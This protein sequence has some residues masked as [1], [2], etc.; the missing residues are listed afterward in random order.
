MKGLMRTTTTLEP[1]VATLVERRMKA[2][3]A[4]FKTVVNDVLRSSIAPE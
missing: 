4:S 3:G 2:T 1:D